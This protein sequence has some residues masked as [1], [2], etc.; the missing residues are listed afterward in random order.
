MNVVFLKNEME[1]INEH[2][3]FSNSYNMISEIIYTRKK[4][5]KEKL[6][7]RVFKVCNICDTNATIM[8]FRRNACMLS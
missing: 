3:F 5:N 1:S 8:K 4:V 6:G 2:K 7:F